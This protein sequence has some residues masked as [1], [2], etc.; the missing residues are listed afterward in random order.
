MLRSVTLC[1]RL[2]LRLFFLTGVTLRFDL[3]VLGCEPLPRVVLAPSSVGEEASRNGTMI[4]LVV[5]LPACEFVSSGSV[6]TVTRIFH[7]LRVCSVTV[8]E[9]EAALNH[10]L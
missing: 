5:D 6:S 9:G 7:G 8:L 10:W 1:L 4:V 3:A 2:L